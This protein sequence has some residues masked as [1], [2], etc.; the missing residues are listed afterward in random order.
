M[1]TSISDLLPML[2]PDVPGCPENRLLHVLRE[3]AREAV[4]AIEGW[5]I[6]LA[7]ISLVANE[8]DYGLDVGEDIEAVRL[9]SAKVGGNLLDPKT[10]S[11]IGLDEEPWYALR[12]SD[13]DTPKTAQ[14]DALV[15]TV[16]VIPGPN[17]DTLPAFELNKFYP[18]IVSLASSRLLA[19]SGRRWYDPQRSIL[20]RRQ[21]WRYITDLCYQRETG[22]LGVSP[23]ASGGGFLSER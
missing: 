2:A 14:T 15:V 4:R 9:L 7:P 11:F 6:E 18:A 16:A 19:E 13:A 21:Y 20:A 8:S 12:F 10:Y 3:S 1:M 22:R 5:T 17:A 23:V